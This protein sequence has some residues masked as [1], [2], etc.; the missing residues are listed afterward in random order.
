MLF[1]SSF[2]GDACPAF[3]LLE[4]LV[5]LVLIAI[6]LGLAVIRIGAAADRVAVRAAAGEAAA[7]FDAARRMAIY[8][9][10]PVAVAIDTGAATLRTRAD[11]T[12]FLRRDLGSSFGVS[13]GASRDSMAYDAKGFGVG[14][15]NLSLIV[16]RGS[17]VDTV[18]LS[19]LGR[20]RY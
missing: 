5:V 17:A 7:V 8:H 1:R 20:V 10:A 2:E 18:F 6:L 14:A 11:T 3:T 13:L 19:R 15:A 9:R 16:R 12:V 4:L